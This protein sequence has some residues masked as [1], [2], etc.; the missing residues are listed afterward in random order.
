VTFLDG[1][2]G[3]D[4]DAAV[5]VLRQHS[6]TLTA[7][8]PREVSLYL[9]FMS[10]PVSRIVMIALSSETLVAAITAQR[11]PPWPWVTTSVTFLDVYQNGAS[12]H[13]PSRD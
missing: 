6:I 2:T 10:A 4:Q 3:T 11:D 1:S 7:R 12:R 13:E 8:P 9:I 5:A